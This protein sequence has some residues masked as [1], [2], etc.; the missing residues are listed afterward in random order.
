MLGRDVRTLLAISIGVHACA[1]PSEQPKENGGAT[2]E[3]PVAAADEQHAGETSS[4]GGASGGLADGGQDSGPAPP[5]TGGNDGGQGPVGG[6][7]STLDAGAESPGNSECSDTLGITSFYAT[8]P[9]GL[10]WTS[11]YWNADAHEL[12]FGQGDPADPQRLANSRGTGVVTVNGDG[13]LTM[14]G[15]QPRI[16]LGTP[17]NHPWLNVEITVY[18]QRLEDDDTAWAGLVVGARGGVDGHGGDNCTATTYYA[19][20]R[21]D[22]NADVE[23]E[24]EHSASEARAS[25]PIWPNEAPLPKARWIGMK[26]IV[27]NDEAGGVRLQVFRD[28][29]EGMNGGDWEPIIDYSDSGGWAP[30][31][32]CDYPPDHIILEGGGVVFVRNTGTTG[33]G[34]LYRQLSVREIDAEAPCESVT[35]N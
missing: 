1:N 28:L 7:P 24:L 31:S 16:Y 27:Y 20:F 8:A 21:H 22:G 30:P 9:A 6:G 3:M 14:T 26:Y 11:E 18:Y 4:G 29:S 2:N 15:S 17:D 25:A 5:A 23:K 19:R 32:N 35:P 33:P 13:T 10:A 34:A 12:P